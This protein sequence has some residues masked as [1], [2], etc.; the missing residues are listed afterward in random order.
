MI[1][2][3]EG[4]DYVTLINELIA[5][6]LPFVVIAV[7]IAGYKIIQIGLNKL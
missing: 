4:F 5:V 3:P 1:T 7:L 2:L 6:S